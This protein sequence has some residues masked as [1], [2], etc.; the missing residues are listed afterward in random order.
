MDPPIAAIYYDQMVTRAS[1][2]TAICA[3][4]SHVLD[5][6]FVVLRDHK[7]F[8]LRDAMAPRSPWKSPGH[9]RRKVQ[10]TGG[11][12]SPQTKRYRQAIAINR[13]RRN[14]KGKKL[15]LGLEASPKLLHGSRHFPSRGYLYPTSNL[16]EKQAPISRAGKAAAQC[17]RK[18]AERVIQLL[19]FGLDKI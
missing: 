6:V 3:C 1:T 9:H 15:E 16:G 11:G 7:P 17:R 2:I 19:E 5:R 13:P 12:P 4:A 14:R 18:P 8:E 10:G